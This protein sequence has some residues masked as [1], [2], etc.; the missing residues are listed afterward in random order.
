MRKMITFA[1]LII[2]V[3]SY[4]SLKIHESS[5][6]KINPGCSLIRVPCNYQSTTIILSFSSY[7]VKSVLLKETDRNPCSSICSDESFCEYQES[8]EKLEFLIKSC[9]SELFLHFFSDV[10]TIVL[11]SAEYLGPCKKNLDDPYVKCATMDKRK[12]LKCGSHCKLSDCFSE[13]EKTGKILIHSQICL[14]E[15]VE[16]SEM[17]LRCLAYLPVE[18]GRWHQCVEKKEK[19]SHFFWVVSIGVIFGLL[20]LVACFMCWRCRKNKKVKEFICGIC[21][22]CM[23]SKRNLDF[24]TNL[25]ELK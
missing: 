6:I 25:V 3:S 19:K 12:C 1:I 22:K 4:P 2:S 20:L 13:D 14:P 17:N 18:S 23:K 10:E 9:F 8:S 11:A 15:F 5:K 21:K 16:D 7:A 24:Q